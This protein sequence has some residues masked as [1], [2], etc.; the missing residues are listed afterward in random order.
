MVLQVR[1]AVLRRLRSLCVLIVAS[2]VGM[3][4][5]DKAPLLAPGGTVI[6]LNATSSSV[7]ATGSVDIIAVLLEQGSTS[8]GGTGSATTP[9]SGTPVHNG[10]LVSFTSTIGRVEPAEARTENGQVRVKFVGDGRSGTATILAYSGGARTEMTLNVGAAAAE[11]VQVSA[12]PV[13]SSGGTSTVQARVEDA[14]GN[15]LSGVSVQFSTTRGTLSSTSATT[16]A[17]GV[18]TVTLTTTAEATV[19]AT[20]GSKSGTAT[21][22]P[23]T[24][25]GLTISAPTTVVASAPAQ[26]TFGLT[27]VAGVRNV[28]VNWGDG[29][30][31]NLGSQAS[32]QQ[33]HTF[34]DSGNY[35]VTATAEMTDGTF[36]PSTTATVT[37][38]AFQ[39]GISASNSNP[40]IN[41]T[42]TFTATVTP[43][44]VIVERYE[45]N[46]GDGGTRVTEGP[47]AT[48]VYEN[49]DQGNRLVSVTVVPS[50]GRSRS[51]STNVVV[52]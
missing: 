26:F 19:T 13:G 18:A 4:A 25:S 21:V 49:G 31:S 24:R 51:N 46:F 9:S 47:V 28:H 22:T 30:T 29:T 38:G 43:N 27:N 6:F 37:A 40:S 36:E 12:T 39:V 11:R 14:S 48:Y 1:R 33:Q 8:T 2:A 50:I 15:P 42:V 44:T 16:D 41:N 32:S 20:A 7:P 45:W 34:P 3:S 23:A 10:T 17:S 35:T 52:Q 5:C